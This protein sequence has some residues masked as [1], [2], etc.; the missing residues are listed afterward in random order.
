MSR[1]R[2]IQAELA[3]F[4]ITVLCRVLGVAC[5]D[6]YAWQRRPPSARQQRAQPLQGA[7]VQVHAASRG[8]DGAPRIHATLQQQ[9]VRCGR[10]R[11]ARIMRQDGLRG[12]QCGCA[13][14]H[15][16]NAYPARLPAPNVLDRGFVAAAPNRIGVGDL[17]YVPTGEGRLY[18]AI[19]LD[20]YSR[21]VMGGRWQTI[22]LPSSR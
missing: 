7:I 10:Q 14:P 22:C 6:F 13:I 5:S 12:I 8:T 1:D 9:G 17:T 2:F 4:P 20:P 15:T 16:T 21:P 18:L 11:I 19:V 3:Q